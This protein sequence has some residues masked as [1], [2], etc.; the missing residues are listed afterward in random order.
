VSRL[1]LG[2]LK[3]GARGIIGG[4]G[5]LLLPPCCAVC[6]S[7]LDDPRQV[8]CPQCFEGF[9]RLA[10]PICA[11]CGQPCPTSDMCPECKSDKTTC[12][13]RS[14]FAFGGSLAEAVLK[15]KFENRCQLAPFFARLIFEANLPG[16][17]LT[18]IDLIVPV[19]LHPAK[20]KERGF[21][22]SAMLAGRI[23]GLLQVPFDYLHL[24]RSRP[25]ESQSRMKTRSEREKNV[26]GAFST[27]KNHPFSARRI[28]LID[29]VVTTGSTLRACSDTLINAGAQSVL[30]ATLARTI[31]W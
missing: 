18:K 8:V 25:T 31:H 16:H 3:S 9:E 19:P 2:A 1:G 10:P 23:A 17:D 13:I 11:S 7:L 20:L 27:T 14:V 28:C 22:Q 30:G 12:S 26:K 29:D 15:F 5:D 4:L 24:V 6:N 21:N